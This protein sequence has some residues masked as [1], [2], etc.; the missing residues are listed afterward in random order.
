MSVLVF[1]LVLLVCL[2]CRQVCALT[3]TAESCLEK[4]F[5]SLTLQ[6]STCQQ[7]TAAVADEDLQAEC[8]AC[9]V[10]TNNSEEVY[11][12]AVLEVDKHFVNSFPDVQAIIKKKKDF[13]LFVR[14]RVGSRPVL[15]VYHNKGDQTPADSIPVSSWNQET[16]VEYLS[17][18]L[19]VKNKKEGGGEL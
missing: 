13:G 1:V 11:H 5:N 19:R 14:Y 6:C 3:L 17:T 10:S 12:W 7:L 16:F 8:R 4:G 15:N 9:C 18:H 2:V